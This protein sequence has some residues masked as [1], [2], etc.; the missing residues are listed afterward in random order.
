M[1]LAEISMYIAI[2]FDGTIVKHKY[3]DIGEA[4]PFAIDWM[5]LFQAAG[6]KLILYTMRSGDE[7]QEAIDYCKKNGVEFIGY[8]VNPTQSSWTDS[9]KCYANLYID[10]AA[11]GCPL[12]NDRMKGGRSYVDWSA[13][14]P[15]VMKQLNCCTEEED[16]DEE[17]E[18]EASE[19][20]DFGEK[21]EA[22]TYKGKTVTLNK[23]FRTKGPKKFAVYVKNDKGNVVVVR[24]GDPNMS[25]KRDD[26]ERRKSFRARHGCDNPG[27]KWKAKYWSCKFWS[28]T[29]VEDLL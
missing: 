24:F 25:I 12:A 8:N 9:P 10:D 4:V 11:F 19:Y 3:P 20:I 28:K 13:V 26:P 23:P 29:D 14:G 17:M 16:E 5:K 1:V 2:D 15:V 27:P 18:V 6:A 21:A 7:L 22:A